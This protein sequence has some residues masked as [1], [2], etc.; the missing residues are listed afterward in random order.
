M[1]K[2]FFAI[3]FFQRLGQHIDHIFLAGAFCNRFFNGQTH[4]FKNAL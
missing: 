4:F 3:V 2:R 1:G